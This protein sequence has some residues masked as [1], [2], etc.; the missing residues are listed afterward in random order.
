MK[1][2]IPVDNKGLDSNVSASFGRSSYFLIYD[3]ESKESE[4]IENT[5]VHSS[6]GAGIKAAQTIVDS[7]A[8]AVLTPRCGQNAAEVLKAA[9]IELYKTVAGNAEE[10]ITA[11]SDKKLSALD[12][13]H[14]GFHG[15]GGGR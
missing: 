13:I 10:N 8:K 1:I 4:F 11:F 2:A 3:T 6:G 14:A 9:G 7:G 15:R 12:D 5:A